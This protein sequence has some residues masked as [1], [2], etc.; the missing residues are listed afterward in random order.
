MNQWTNE[1]MNVRMTT[2]INIYLFFSMIIIKANK[3][4]PHHTKH[5]CLSL[6]TRVWVSYVLFVYLSVYVFRW[7]L[8][9]LTSFYICSLVH[10]FTFVIYYY[11]FLFSVPLFPFFAFFLLQI[12]NFILLAV[13]SKVPWFVC[14]SY[15]KLIIIVNIVS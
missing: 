8:F 6:F 4:I 13:S 14:F 1:L 9:G 15:L 5:T 3:R 2:I 12:G 10:S 11:L 7:V